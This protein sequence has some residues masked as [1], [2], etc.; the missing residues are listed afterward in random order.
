MKKLLQKTI[1]LSALALF[2]L[3]KST[4][5]Q[6]VT[7]LAGSTTSG[8]ADGI[9]AS[10]SFKLPTGVAT[11]ASGNIY[12]A[13]KYN[14]EIRKIVIATGVVSTI[15]GSGTIGHADGAGTTASFNYPNGV[16]TDANGNLYV[17]D[18]SNNEIR[19]IDIAT[20]VVTTLAGSTTAGHADGTGATA[21]FNTPT[22]VATD[23]N[24]NLYVADQNNY[25][26]RKIVIATGVVTTLAGS[27][28]F[29]HA[30]G[31]G[32]AASFF[33]PCGVA[34]DASGN[35]YVADQLNNE[36]RKIDI[37]TGAV[38]TL[39]GSTT[40]GHADGT[41][42]AASFNAPGG[43]AAD[44]SG[45]LYVTDQY[46]NEIRKIDI[47]TGAVTTLAGSTTAGHADGIGATASF[48]NP[49][50]VT[51]DANGNLYVADYTNNEIRA[52]SSGSGSGITKNKIVNNEIIIYP[53]PATNM[54]NVNGITG[55]AT[56]KLYDVLG[57]LIIQ[58]SANDNKLS[59]DVSQF[60]NGV[61]TFVTE[62]IDAKTTN[63]III[64]K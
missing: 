23:A 33:F 25:E 40:A 8:A 7:T 45:N 31:T 59:I 28:T 26:I 38:T 22:G 4:N 54:I 58:L 62:T 64:N 2:G 17:A 10:A 11:D 37:A 46:N 44:A 57:N 47:A 16:A 30:D 55:K 3:S 52:I 53:N 43:V 41:G 21:S 13:D 49:W 12:V 24:G 48:K 20:G 14:H 51:I 35:L 27:T 1:L 56:I 15:A 5:A 32:A 60:T 61:Y 39:A 18:A 6:T 36:I 9:G 19:K 34:T 63:K 50:S 42:A 29:G